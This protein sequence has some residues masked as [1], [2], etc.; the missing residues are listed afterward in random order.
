MNCQTWRQ[1]PNRSAR[2][3]RCACD[4]LA[5]Q[6]DKR[7]NANKWIV[8]GHWSWL[9]RV[10][11]FLQAVRPSVVPSARSFSQMSNGGSPTR[12]ENDVA[13]ELMSLDEELNMLKWYK[14]A[15]ESAL[16]A[17][18]VKNRSH[19]KQPRYNPAAERYQERVQL[20]RRVIAEEQN[21]PL[22]L[23]YDE[24]VRLTQKE[25]EDLERRR[26]Q[27]L[28][29]YDRVVDIMQ[30][31]S[32]KEERR[33][34]YATFLVRQ[35][36]EKH[37]HQLEAQIIDCKRR[38][39]PF[40]ELEAKIQDLQLEAAQ[41]AEDASGSHHHHHHPN[42]VAKSM[43]KLQYE[44]SMG[45]LREVE[46]KVWDVAGHSANVASGTKLL[47]INTSQEFGMGFIDPQRSALVTFKKTHTS[48]KIG[49]PSRTQY[50]VR[51]LPG[52]HEAL[53][54]PRPQAEILG[55]PDIYELPR[56][57]SSPKRSSRSAPNARALS[58]AGAGDGKHAAS[59]NDQ[60]DS[61]R[62]ARAC[63]ACPPLTLHS[64]SMS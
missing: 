38:N 42:G 63:P 21:R 30:Q 28:R 24:F 14:I 13:R 15:N 37:I 3:L 25:D 46:S 33:N 40:D 26:E 32:E 11:P 5:A 58:E 34:R 35:A 19:K 44:K 48:A 47:S 23:P 8:L 50:S 52:Q 51:L 7:R 10:V 39:L 18:I 29:R 4:A 9:V 62:Y 16:K 41:A 56:T 54:P 43:A 12:S 17:A 20:Q 2:Q 49:Q 31:L 59:A 27:A 6:N 36:R 53:K 57:A 64:G 1:L 60:T 45:M 55:L 22:E 61:E